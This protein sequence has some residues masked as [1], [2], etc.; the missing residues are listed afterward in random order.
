MTVTGGIGVIDEFMKNSSSTNS[1]NP[2]KMGLSDMGSTPPMGN[3]VPS[4][5][6][7]QRYGVNSAYGSLGVESSDERCH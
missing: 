5:T 6:P 3:P 1:A 7:G 4:L 2:C